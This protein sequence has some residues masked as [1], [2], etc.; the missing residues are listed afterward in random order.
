MNGAFEFL[1]ERASMVGREARRED[2]LLMI[3]ELG[4]NFHNLLRRFACAENHLWETLAQRA[5]RVHLRKT[6][7]RDWRGLKGLQDFIAS[8][9]AGAEFFQE[10]NR[11]G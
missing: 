4:G 6:N 9:A 7:I 10:L 2:I 1:P 3:E 8:H 5:M 11:F